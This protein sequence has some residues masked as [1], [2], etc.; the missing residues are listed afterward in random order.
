MSV[1][2]PTLASSNHWSR[3]VVVCKACQKLDSCRC[4][5]AL[6]R[7][8]SA[9][10]DARNMQQRARIRVGGT[11]DSLKRCSLFCFVCFDGAP[12][13]PACSTATGM[14]AFSFFAGYWV[15]EISFIFELAAA[16]ILN[17]AA[18]TANTLII[19]S[20]YLLASFVSVTVV[21]GT[22]RCSS[23]SKSDHYV[24]DVVGRFP[25]STNVLAAL[26]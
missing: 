9:G 13:L 3:L 26:I 11:A 6:S 17:C 16:V 14:S 18:K 2:A 25:H 10:S 5:K 12:K 1:V 7:D 20:I 22:G 15:N 24:L 19:G 4:T 23:I 8:A 21:A